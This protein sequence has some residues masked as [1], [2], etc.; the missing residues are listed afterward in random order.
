M[1]T[2]KHSVLIEGNCSFGVYWVF[3]LA[4]TLSQT[5]LT[6]QLRKNDNSSPPPSFFINF[7]TPEKDHV[8]KCKQ[9]NC[10]LLPSLK[11]AAI[12]LMSIQIFIL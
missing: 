6:A 8:Q 9:S 4:I 2:L 12:A 3:M 7:L 10:S 5:F 1:S 11:N